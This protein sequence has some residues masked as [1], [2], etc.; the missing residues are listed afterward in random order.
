MDSIWLEYR[1]DSGLVVNAIVYE[2][3]APYL[4]PE[5]LALVERGSS[6]AWIG[7]TYSG[8]EFLPPAEE[9]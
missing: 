6:N 2:E 5:G 8:G 7:W 9:E 3:G 4:P 1:L